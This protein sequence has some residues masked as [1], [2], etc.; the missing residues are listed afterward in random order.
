MY[1]S[2]YYFKTFNVVGH[3]QKSPN[4]KTDTQ[5]SNDYNIFNMVFFLGFGISAKTH[6]I[7]YFKKLVFMRF[8]RNFSKP[9]IW[10][11]KS[12]K[13]KLLNLAKIFPEK[14]NDHE[15]FTCSWFCEL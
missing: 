14:L 5:F 8:L 12:P 2:N 15:I 6:E 3:P 1:C 10:L 7:M 11:F 13:K 4:T 9:A